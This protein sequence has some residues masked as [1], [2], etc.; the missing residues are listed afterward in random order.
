MILRLISKSKRVWDINEIF[1]FFNLHCVQFIYLI[2]DWL[3]VHIGGQPKTHI[4]EQ[5]YSHIAA[6]QVNQELAQ[7]DAYF[8]INKIK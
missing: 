5:I 2:F 8:Y 6:T 3:L 7:D 4:H 1:F